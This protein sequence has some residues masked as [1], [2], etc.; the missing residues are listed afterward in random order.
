LR[1]ESND[2]LCQVH[3][4]AIG[5]NRSP[6]DV[7]EVLEV[8]DDRLGWSPGISILLA[9]ANIM[10]RLESLSMV[11]VSGRAQRSYKTTYA[12]LP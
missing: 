5:A 9:Y 11:L 2:G 7:V 12:V 8:E 6:D 4:R 1:F 10:V 3:N